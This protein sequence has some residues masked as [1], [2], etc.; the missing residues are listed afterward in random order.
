MSANNTR[1]YT[2]TANQRQI[3]QFINIKNE[4]LA[5]KVQCGTFMNVYS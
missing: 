3:I 2:H 5:T 4:R 1:T